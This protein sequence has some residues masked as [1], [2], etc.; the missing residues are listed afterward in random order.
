MDTD[1]IQAQYDMQTETAESVVLVYDPER[2]AQV[3]VCVT[4]CPL[5]CPSTIVIAHV[6][7]HVQ[8][9]Y[10]HLSVSL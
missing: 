8:H 10:T 2:T 4:A 1:L 6:S 5:S 3:C 9:I 7:V